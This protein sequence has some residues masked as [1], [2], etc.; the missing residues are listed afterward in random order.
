MAEMLRN[1]LIW[2]GLSALYAALVG[3]WRQGALWRAYQWLCENYHSSLVK[4]LWRAWGQAPD[5]AE[6]SLYRQTLACLRRGV[7]ALGDWLRQSLLWRLLQGLEQG[8]LWLGQRSLVVGWINRLPARQWLLLAF[9]WY[10]PI[11]YVLRDFLHL[12]GLASVWEE[13]FMALAVLAVL[14]RIALRRSRALGRETILDAWL[15]LFMAMGF[16]LMCFNQP[17]PQVAVAGYRIVVQYMLWFFIILRM[18]EDDRD[19][20]VLLASLGLLLA[21]LALHGVYQFIIGVPIPDAWTSN[22]EAGVRTR[23]YSLTGSPN[24]L[25]SLLVLLTPL[26]AA[27]LYYFHDK[28][29]K[30]ASLGLV[31][32]ALLCLLF[33]FS[34][35]AW[36]G[37]MLTVGLFSLFVDRRLLALMAGACAAILVAVPSIT[38]RITFLFSSEYAELTAMGGRA[39][40][41]TT[42]L[43]LLH[44]GNPW[45]GYG[46]GMFGG[47]VAME[48]QLLDETEEFYY[49][50]M[51]NYYLKTLV[52]MGYLGF[53]LYALLLLAVIYI[54]VKAIFRADVRFAGN[55]GDNLVRAEGNMRLWAIA[56]FSGLCGVLL[57]CYFE[58][59]FE[60]PYMSAYFWGLTA[61]LLYIGLFRPKTNTP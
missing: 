56:I 34:R 4:A 40:R 23:V 20:K 11:E 10:L 47:A 32:L 38:S 59:I 55:S 60:E 13:G 39:F 33:T 7:E 52:E 37:M 53:I 44:E 6:R 16:F 35:G 48:H 61:A 24:I 27:A 8:W 36:M 26:A 51:D 15:L 45:L 12:Y 1:S 21:F 28:R 22:A 19:L 3:W 2:R 57:H 43:G 58:N 18:L 29:V 5:A 50:Y 17:Y 9:G 30:I 46:L 31:L 49:F 42:G 25:G 41:W 54:G 14:W